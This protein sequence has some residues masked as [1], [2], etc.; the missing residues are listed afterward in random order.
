MAENESF[1]DHIWM[2]TEMP[3]SPS[4]V[5]DITF[6]TSCLVIS[7]LG[8]VGNCL[9][10]WHFY[11]KN[12]L[13]SRLYKHICGIDIVICSSQIPVIQAFLNGRNPGMF[14][15]KIFCIFWKIV[16]EISG[17]LYAMAV[18][19][20]STSRTVAIVNPLYNI[21]KWLVIT[22]LYV[23]L[24]FL[25]LHQALT[26]VPGFEIG[27][28]ADSVCC[29][30]HFN[31]ETTGNLTNT[32]SFVNT[33]NFVLLSIE[34]GVPAILT[35]FSFLISTTKL[36]FKS[37]IPS[38][39]LQQLRA[40]IT[41]AIFT[42]VFLICYLPTFA[43]MVLTVYESIAL[44]E[45]FGFDQGLLSKYFIFWY[46]WPLCRFLLTPLN[47]TLDFVIYTS[48]MKDF[49][50]RLTQ[51]MRKRRDKIDTVSSSKRRTMIRQL[52]E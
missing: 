8:F 9:A 13:A 45:K 7:L 26:F 1:E 50:N 14:S 35:F 32:Q 51:M 22:A 44:K 18:L 12:D 48:R 36:L 49:R 43:L 16:N 20:L 23:Y 21:K 29:Y 47:A 10:L 41:I 11:E 17:T 15:N 27:Y 52:S 34:C 19:L 25:G 38:T 39:Q 4:A 46:A 3:S 28:G 6:G 42:I 31:T 40:A 37:M 2:Y 24:L 30:S 5:W 33:V